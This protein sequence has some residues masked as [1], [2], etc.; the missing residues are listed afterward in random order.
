MSVSLLGSEIERA[1]LYHRSEQGTITKFR[2]SWI[3]DCEADCLELHTLR[4]R[5]PQ[6]RQRR[7]QLPPREIGDED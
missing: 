1:G 6:R 5:D 7:G 2:S 3:S 4:H